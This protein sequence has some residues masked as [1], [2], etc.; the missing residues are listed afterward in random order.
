MR[1]KGS[2]DRIAP[3]LFHQLEAD[4]VVLAEVFVC[5]RGEVVFAEVGFTQ[6]REV[7]RRVGGGIGFSFAR[8]LTC[9][10]LSEFPFHRLF[11][12]RLKR[13]VFLAQSE[14]VVGV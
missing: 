14:V 9:E 5:E 10:T 8:A 3:C 2:L 13:L 6:F 12:S 11:V 7:F 1:R 4:G